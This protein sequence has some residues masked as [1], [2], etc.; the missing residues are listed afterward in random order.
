MRKINKIIV[1]CSATPPD[2]DIGAT[3]IRDWHTNGNGWIDIGY[4]YVIRRSGD[5][6]KGRLDDVIGAH[7]RGHNDDS[8]SICLVGGV[9]VDKKPDCNFTR[10]QWA[11]LERKVGELSFTYADATVIGHRDVSSKAC[12]C[13]DVN[14]W[15]RG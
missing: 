8:I 9:D 12:P 5:L 3:E 13:F 2:L 6:E 1:H 7:A 10:E 4:H 14:Q 11:T 15:W